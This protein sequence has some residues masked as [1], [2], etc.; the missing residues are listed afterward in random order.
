MLD[1]IAG[2][3]A[4]VLEESVHDELEVIG[5][6][7]ADLNGVYLRNGPNPRYAPQ[8]RYH[9]F[10]GDGMIHAAHFDRGRLTYR[11]RWVRTDAFQRE[12]AQSRALYWGVMESHKARA[13]KPMKD[14][15]NTDVIGH[16]GVA[17][18]SW[19]LAGEVYRVHPVTL[20]TLGKLPVGGAFSAHPKVDLA[21]GELIYFDYQNEPPYMSHGVIGVD[22]RPRHRVAIDLPGPR[23]PHDMAIT[24]RYS[25]LHDLPLFHDMEALRA[26]RHK[27]D[28]HPELPAR[29]GV[30]PRHGA[31]DAIRWFEAPACWVY[32]TVNAWEDGDEVVMV[33]CRYMPAGGLDAR[34][35]A[36]MIAELEMDA[37][38]CRWRFNMKTGLA[39]EE[40]IDPEHNV[41]FPTSNARHTGRPGRWAYLME[42]EREAPHFT[43]LVKQDTVSGRRSRWSDGPGA[44]YSEAP[45]APADRAAAE[46][47]GYLVSFVWNEAT[48]R[49][50]I[51]VFD[52]RDVERG[53]V[54]RALV[55][56]RIPAGFH[57]AWIESRHIAA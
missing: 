37:R 27:I 43:A 54:A 52:A 29:F 50:E 21:T 47:D 49:S 25:I 14:S 12:Q 42:Q 8:G 5:E 23:L 18:A 20:E 26:G 32:H 30:I 6:I 45:F 44:Y 7:P 33:G 10:D 19:Y 34:R 16:N 48:R 55:P 17:L 40:I 1:M 39:K 38:L 9:W 15:A 36:R 22:G 2:P 4:P 53:P 56:Q 57:A 41:E 11:N 24:E 28:F 51:Q 13:D 31:G 35:T 46:D 3:Y